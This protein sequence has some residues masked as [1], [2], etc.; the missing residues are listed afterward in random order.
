L[1]TH[2][3]KLLIRTKGDTDEG[4]DNIY[5]YNRRAQFK[6]IGVKKNLF[7][8]YGIYGLIIVLILFMLNLIFG[9][10]NKTKK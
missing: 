6:V 4:D 2:N 9:K 3:F 5:T 1:R 8:K 7:V 10:K